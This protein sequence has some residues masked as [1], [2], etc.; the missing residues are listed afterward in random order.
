[1]PATGAAPS[2][3]CCVSAV[4]ARTGERST[5]NQVARVE[6]GVASLTRSQRAPSMSSGCEY[7]VYC[8]G[9]STPQRSVMRSVEE[10]CHAAAPS[11]AGSASSA[12]LRS[13]RVDGRASISDVHSADDASGAGTCVIATGCNATRLK[14]TRAPTSTPSTSATA[15]PRL[16]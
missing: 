14:N 15:S 5:V 9:A 10:A 13:A 12:R 8:A 16:M 11:G 2:R 7:G 6:P 1:M 3:S 4:T